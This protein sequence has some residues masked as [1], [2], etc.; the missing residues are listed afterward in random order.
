V[1]SDKPRRFGGQVSRL[2]WSRFIKRGLRTPRAPLAD[3]DR[4]HSARAWIHTPDFVARGRLTIHHKN[5]TTSVNRPGVLTCNRFWYG[6]RRSSSTGCSLAGIR[7]W[8]GPLSA[9][10]I[11][12]VMQRL[13]ASEVG[14]SG[15]NELQTMRKFLEADDG[16]E[17]YMLNLV[18]VAPVEVKGPDGV[19]RPA[20][21]V[22]EEYTK[23]FMP[24]L[25][26]RGGYPAIVARRARRIL[27][28]L[29]RRGR[30]WLDDHRLHALSKQA[31]P[32]GTCA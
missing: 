17:F 20:R 14:T 9:V 5:G 22:I 23:V 16:R 18:R 21:E 19:V 29:G 26:A 10:E 13:E 6:F 27:R 7:N 2:R 15:R 30:P 12:N 32:C 31:R 11:S 1:G 4:R 3:K 8:G 24:S 25:F 28:C